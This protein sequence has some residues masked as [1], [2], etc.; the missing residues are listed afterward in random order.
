MRGSGKDGCGRENER[1]E[2]RKVCVRGIWEEGSKEGRR[3]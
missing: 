2:G 1:E 3:V